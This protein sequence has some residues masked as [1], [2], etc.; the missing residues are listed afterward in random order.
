[1]IPEEAT[2]TF[3]NPRQQLASDGHELEE[4]TSSSGH[5]LHARNMKIMLIEV[6]N[7]SWMFNTNHGG[8]KD[9]VDGLNNNSSRFPFKRNSIVK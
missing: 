4:V 6:S 3:S 1:M 7:T 9:V 5:M 8:D 2:S